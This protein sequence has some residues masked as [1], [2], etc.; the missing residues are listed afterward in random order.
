MKRARYEEGRSG[1]R[2]V[3]EQRKTC[4]KRDTPCVVLR[5]GAHG[6]AVGAR[7]RRRC[8]LVA[9]MARVSRDVTSG[10]Y[11]DT[12]GSLSGLRY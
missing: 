2:I 3:S 4:C 5:N 8:A 9:H 12:W 10:S 6:T 7:E 11:A 1:P